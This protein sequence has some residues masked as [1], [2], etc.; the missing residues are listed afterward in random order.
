MATLNENNSVS[1]NESASVKNNNG[2]LKNAGIGVAGAAAGAGGAMA[3]MS[4]RAS[5][6]PVSNPDHVSI[7]QS[8]HEPDHFN[9]A[10]VPIA[11]NV[12]DGMSFNEAFAAARHE[13]G[14]GGVF[15]WHGGVYGTYYANEWDGFSDTYKHEFSNYHYDIESGQHV[16]ESH[17]TTIDVPIVVEDPI[18]GNE[19]PSV[20]SG[21]TGS[22][23]LDD[24]Q[25][26]DNDVTV[27]SSGHMDIDGHTV[28]V[29][30]A[31]VDGHEVAL[32]DTNLDGNYDI[33]VVNNNGD[34][35]HSSVYMIDNE[36]NGSETIPDFHE[37]HD[38][39][40][41]GH[42]TLNNHEIDHTDIL[43]DFNNDA[44]IS[45]FA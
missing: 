27:I 36:H 35:E 30:S 34:P 1:E 7:T 9:G 39:P 20:D 5:D 16:T 45:N 13:V 6:E 31:L 26:S 42:D 44:D 8:V 18:A 38:I 41:F 10:D 4:F 28:D 17:P 33:A 43:P 21:V 23:P 3:A 25:G 24:I 29:V 12:D 37:T 19:H 40:D 15:E 22:D 2:V 11:Q 32:V 14:A